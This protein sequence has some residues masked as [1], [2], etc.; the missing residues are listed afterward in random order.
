MIEVMLLRLEESEAG[1]GGS[2]LFR[3]ESGDL[4]T[5]EVELAGG[6]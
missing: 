2:G 4:G 6:I 3:S 5:G 1:G